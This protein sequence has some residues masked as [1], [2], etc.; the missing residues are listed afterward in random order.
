LVRKILPSILIIDT[1]FVLAIE[2]TGHLEVLGKIRDLTKNA[3]LRIYTPYGVYNEV[4]DCNEHLA[5]LLS[6]FS[7]IEKVNHDQFFKEIQRICVERHYISKDEEVDVEVMA[8]AALKSENER[9][10]IVTFDEGIMR[11]VRN[12]PKLRGIELIYPWR[13]PFYLIPFADS[14]TRGEL[15][16]T[17]VDVYKYFYDYRVRSSRDVADLVQ[18][19]IE[20]AVL[21]MEISSESIVD[22]PHDLLSAANKYLS[23]ERLSSKEFNLIED[24]APLLDYLKIARNAEDLKELEGSLTELVSKLV[25]MSTKAN[26]RDFLQLAKL[27][28]L[29]SLKSRFD[30]V[31][32]YLERNEIE[33]ARVG[34]DFLRNLYITYCDEVNPEY[35]MKMHTMMS[36]LYI[37]E[38][39]YDLAVSCLNV[40]KDLAPLDIR[41]K[42]VS[43]LLNLAMGNFDEAIGLL[44]ELEEAKIDTFNL[45]VNSAHDFILRKQYAMAAKLLMIAEKCKNYNREVVEKK[46]IILLKIAQD[47]DEDTKN[48]LMTLVSKDKLKDHTSKPLDKRLLGE[49]IHVSELHP[50]LKGEMLVMRTLLLPDDRRILIVWNTALKSKIG[51]IVPKE[52]KDNVSGA[53]SIAMVDGIV[54]KIRGPN[55]QEKSKYHVRGIIELS[56]DIQLNV[57]KWKILM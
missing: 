57:E 42:I 52:L 54:E 34:L 40:A 35:L 27:I 17:V 32:A 23:D 4:K 22:L 31:R 24:I 3:D 33:K 5:L 15:K 53:M 13:Y 41:G 37:L 50:T 36:M 16:S 8:L 1:N 11:A 7:E 44:S 28:N 51:I 29:L 30:L 2:K 19:L 47:L 43:L 48:K 56:S 25:I 18:D 39:K 10:G 14:S 6:N 49:K 26:R 20:D 38:G 9:V 12:I 46:A 45:V 55:P 21:V